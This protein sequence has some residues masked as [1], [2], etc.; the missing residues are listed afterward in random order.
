[1]AS[2]TCTKRYPEISV[3]HRHWRAQTHCAFIHGYARSTEITIGCDALD[4]RGWVVDLGDLRAIRRF[5]EQ[6]WDH[7]LLVADDDP[8]L[9]ELRA[10]EAKGGLHLNVMD[11]SKGWAPTLEGSCRYVY[12]HAQAIVQQATQGRARVVKVEIW[13]KADNRAALILE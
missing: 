13:E 9:P 4:A 5:L 8:L 1:M 11:S 12:D 2:Y 10:L 3:A 7:R 6:A